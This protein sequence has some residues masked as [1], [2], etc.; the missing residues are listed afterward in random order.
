M[1]DNKMIKN[2]EIRTVYQGHRVFSQDARQQIN[3][4]LQQESGN[5]VIIVPPYS[6]LLGKILGKWTAIDTHV[7]DQDLGG[8]GSGI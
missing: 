5:F 6:F 7:I 1:L 2:V 3:S 8:N 4:L